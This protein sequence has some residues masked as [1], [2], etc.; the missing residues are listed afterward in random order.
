M[1]ALKPATRQKA[2][3]PHGLG[4]YLAHPSRLSAA[5]VGDAAGKVPAGDGWLFEMKY[6]GY[7]MQAAIAGD[8][9]RLYTRNGHDWTQA[10]RLRRP[11]AI[12]PHQGHRADRWRAVR[13]RRA[14]PLELHAAQEQ[15]RWPSAGR[16]LRLRPARTGRRGHRR[17]AP[18]RAQTAPGSSYWR[19]CR[20]IL[21][22]VYSQHVVGK[23]PAGL[24][25]DD[26][27]RLRGCC[28]EVADRPLLRRRS[29]DG[30]AQGQMRQRQEF[31]VIGWRPPGLRRRDVRGLFLGP[32]RT[33]S[34]STAA[35]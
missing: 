29:F 24:R 25:R 18:A 35:A 14:W 12:A 13:H 33:D 17:A 7:R 1:A 15:P 4:L 6:D 32:M 2:V 23:R 21:P 10:V 3:A 19:V 20:P 5:P 16:V 31:V 8:Q 11:G 28:R 22:S 34:S 27:R 26:G 9:V 30:L